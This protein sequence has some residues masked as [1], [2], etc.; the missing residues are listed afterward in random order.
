MNTFPSDVDAVLGELR[1]V[2]RQAEQQLAGNA[3]FATA[4]RLDELADSLRE[5]QSAGEVTEQ[6]LRA[7]VFEMDG[8]RA[9]HGLRLVPEPVHAAN[10]EAASEEQ[11]VTGNAFYMGAAVAGLSAGEVAREAGMSVREFA[12]TVADKTGTTA[13]QFGESV[14]GRA[15][16]VASA[17]AEG[18][19]AAGISLSEFARSVA[20]KSGE[21]AQSF[22]QS[23]EAQATETAHEAQDAAEGAQA[24]A[25]SAE[26]AAERYMGQPAEDMPA[27]AAEPSAEPAAGHQAAPEAPE[28][29]IAHD[30]LAQDAPSPAVSD[31]SA[32][33]IDHAQA[34]GG[35]DVA[36]EQHASASTE[37]S[38]AQSWQANVQSER[39][40]GA[41]SRFF[42][43]LLG[44]KS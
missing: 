29:A 22:A 23:V 17:A 1:A 8:I 18:A 41:V 10:D 30:A 35:A 26:Q 38:A 7:V 4:S 27:H 28:S 6:F 44:R 21:T 2:R 13:H 3:Y 14:A 19:R 34:G 39:S 20:E 16:E 42:R 15:S 31:L 5:A 12:Q 37:E 11:P 43:A 24:W 25:Q 36:P 40:E 33:R 9:R 32:V